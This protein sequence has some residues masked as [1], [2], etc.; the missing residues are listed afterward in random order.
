ML[1]IHPLHCGH[2]LRALVGGACLVGSAS[3][4]HAALVEYTLGGAITSVDETG[5]ALP[6]GLALGDAFV[7]KI[8]F[9]SSTGAT[10]FPTNF[11]TPVGLFYDAVTDFG[12]TVPGNFFGPGEI[13]LHADDGI[14]YI[15]DNS[16]SDAIGFLIGDP[17]GVNIVAVLGG[18]DTLF[19]SDA[20]P[21]TLNFADVSAAL[22]QFTIA[23]S[24]DYN[25]PDARAIG[26]VTAFES[27]IIPA[28]GTIGLAALAVVAPW[29]RQRAR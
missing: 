23:G 10:A 20:L 17:G 24:G 18:P 19:P 16:G 2:G 27:R 14:Q 11:P 6:T 21:E 12:L 7:L 25:S 4:A 1:S 3:G 13:P 8:V 29:S 26:V 22:V 5:A 15:N 28:P 9:D